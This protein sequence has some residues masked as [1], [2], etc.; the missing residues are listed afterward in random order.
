MDSVFPVLFLIVAATVMVVSAQEYNKAIA[1]MLTLATVAVAL[2]LVLPLFETLLSSV[3]GVTEL[4]M[5]GPFEVVVK[6]IGISVLTQLVS[7]LC[8]DCNQR[9]L[10]GLVGLCGKL[11]I[12]FAA[13]PL[14]SDMTQRILDMI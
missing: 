14:L 8:L 1:F 12:I 7:E 3:D 10:S 11:A 4:V 13:L 5:A 9:A 2:F 6:A